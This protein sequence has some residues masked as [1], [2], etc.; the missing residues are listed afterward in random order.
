VHGG[1]LHTFLDTHTPCVCPVLMAHLRRDANPRAAPRSPVHSSLRGDPCTESET[2]G[3]TQVNDLW[4]CP[5]QRADSQTSCYE[6]HASRC[7]LSCA[8]PTPSTR[9][10]GKNDFHGVAVHIPVA[11]AYIHH[12]HEGPLCTASQ[13]PL[14]TSRSAQLP[15]RRRGGHRAH[16]GCRHHATTQHRC[17]WL[18]HR[19]VPCSKVRVRA[20]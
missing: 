9:D 20:P 8:L 12:Q 10:R 16:Y 1:A 11:Y 13:T 6:T 15:K 14:C 5:T 18:R 19:L 4:V 2:G 7:P 3:F 17:T